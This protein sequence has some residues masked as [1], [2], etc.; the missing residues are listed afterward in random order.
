MS[1]TALGAI[2]VFINGNL[3]M[4]TVSKFITHVEAKVVVIDTDRASR[5]AGNVVERATII[6]IETIRMVTR[7]DAILTRA[8][9]VVPYIHDEDDIVLI[10]HSSGTTGFPKPVKYRH[11]NM[12]FGIKQFL[13]NPPEFVTSKNKFGEPKILSLLPKAHHSSFTYFIRAVLAQ[14]QFCALFDAAPDEVASHISQFKPTAVVA[15][16]HNY[17]ALSEFDVTDSQHSFD[18][19][20]WW[21]SV[22]DAVHHRHIYKL[23]SHGHSAMGGEFSK[24]STFIDGLGSSEMGSIFFRAF[25]RHDHKLPFRC[26]GYPQEWVT[27]KIFT[28]DGLDAPPMTVG[29]L[30][31][32]AP[33]LAT[34]WN[35]DDMDDI[36]WIGDFF[37]TGD[38]AY[39]NAEGMYF[40]VDRSGDAVL[41][42]SGMLYSTLAEELILDGIPSI[43]EC[44]IIAERFGGDDTTSAAVC[45]VCCKNPSDIVE[46]ALK[47]AINEVLVNHA[48]P[49]IDKLCIC[50]IGDL[51]KGPTGKIRKV[52]LRAR[53]LDTVNND[54]VTLEYQ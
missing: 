15:F 50:E 45:F 27:A 21:L 44:A 32:C 18:S 17:A 36:S 1:L 22:G 3:P 7:L 5:L 20:S 8:N 54:L 13:N 31:V 42:K 30:G 37:L 12:C 46:E 24:G 11:K 34:Y 41:T 9:G 53:I 10:C 38:L 51:P 48:I 40:H 52:Q 28:E 35:K 47:I 26:I 19:V 29:R 16:P 49:S 23:I 39:R 33:T 2:P 14:I 4:D 25:H 43:N 6:D